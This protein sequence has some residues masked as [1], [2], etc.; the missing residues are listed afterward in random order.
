M[1]FTWTSALE[2]KNEQIDTEHKS[3]I[4]AINNLLDACSKGKGRAEIANTVDFLNEYTKTHFSHEEALQQKYRYPD[5][6]NHKKLH[7]G[8]IKT[9]EETSE[10]LKKEGPTIQLVGEINA[11]LGNWLL[12]HI[13]TED[14]KIARH[15]ELVSK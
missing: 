6:V 12:K 13:K 2:T 3:L 9:V 14:V 4:D 11:Q 1:A 8:F 15:I 10:K 5:Y 7:E